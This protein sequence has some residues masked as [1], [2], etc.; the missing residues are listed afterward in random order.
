MSGVASQ[1]AAEE[2][3]KPNDQSAHINLKVKGQIPKSEGLMQQLE[4]QKGTA[5]LDSSQYPIVVGVNFPITR[6]SKRNRV[7]RE[8][9]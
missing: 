4:G 5:Y 7:E 6:R 2:D 8:R 9:L 3:K 1:P